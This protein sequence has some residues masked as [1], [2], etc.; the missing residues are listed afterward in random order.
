MERITI[1]AQFSFCSQV[2]LGCLF[3][4]PVGGNVS[5]DVSAQLF[6]L[7]LWLYTTAGSSENAKKSKDSPLKLTSNCWYIILNLLFDIFPRKR[8]SQ[9][10]LV[11][12][13]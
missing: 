11:S 8:D 6:F 12:E 5:S 13:S 4:I 9:I 7:Y 10:E 2:C 3:H 1:I